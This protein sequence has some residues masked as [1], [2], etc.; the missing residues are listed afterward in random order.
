MTKTWQ[1]ALQEARDNL[2]SAGTDLKEVREDL[3]EAALNGGE[4]AI[5]GLE[6]WLLKSSIVPTTP[7]MDPEIFPWTKTLED[8]WKDMRAELDELLGRRD[9]LPNFQ[10]ISRDVASISDDDQ[11]KT[12]FFMGYGYRSAANWERCPK[13]AA[14]L[15]QVPGMT[16]AFFSILS[17]G[18]HLPPHRGPYRGVLRYHLGLRIPEPKE[19][20]GI[21][22]GGETRHWE[23]GK[24]LLFDD[25]YQHSAWN[26][27]TELRA[28]LF[29]D[30]VRPMSGAAKVTNDAL[31]KAIAYSPFLRDAKKRHE[32]WERRFEG[33]I[34]Q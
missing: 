13:T 22:V 31:L 7:F 25:G 14:L 6:G 16:T 28:V 26:D 12:V 19:L 33:S 32:A 21:E 27:S 8:G 24:S 5:F 23:E 4:A 29:L 3:R 17:P 18:K 10:D 20:C 15:E 2:R 34:R 9:D 1:V 11:W 30:V